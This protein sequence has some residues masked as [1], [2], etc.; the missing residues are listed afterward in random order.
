MKISF[1][2]K[3]AIQRLDKLVT[4]LPKELRVAQSKA[5]K[6]GKSL[7]AKAVTEELATPQKAV[8]KI[9][10]TSYGPNGEVE[11]FFPKTRRMSLRQPTV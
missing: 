9:I 4:N 2:D 3:G 11:L 10:K 8:R 6:R 7:I 5:A 1:D